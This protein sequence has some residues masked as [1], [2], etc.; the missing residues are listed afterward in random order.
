MWTLKRTIGL[1]LF[2]VVL[3]GCTTS[4]GLL[5]KSGQVEPGMTKLEVISILGEPQRRSFR[6]NAEALQFCQTGQLS[7]SYVNVWLV[8]GKV[9][10]LTSYQHSADFFCTSEIREIDWGQL[11]PDLKVILQD[12]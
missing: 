12:R 2:A 3:T 4:G 5:K 1:A 10:S 11:P 9:I 8:D 6:E 7:D